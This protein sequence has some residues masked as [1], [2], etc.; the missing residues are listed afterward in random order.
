MVCYPKVQYQYQDQEQ[1]L[2]CALRQRKTAVLNP[3][4]HQLYKHLEIYLSQRFPARLALLEDV[5]SNA[6]MY[7]LNRIDRPDFQ[8]INLH[9]F[10]FGI[11][12]GQLRDQVRKKQYAFPVAPHELPEKAT[13]YAIEE[14]SLDNRMFEAANTALYEWYLQLSSRDQQL[15]EL[16]LKG[17]PQKE[18]AKAFNL[19]YGTVRN[20]SRRLIKKAEYLATL[21]E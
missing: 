9:N 21:T 14:W 7:F 11:V 2:L 20:K 12:L 10:A 4:Y 1:Q 17:Y 8:A 15:L 3:F 16:R 18:I 19:S 13:H 6:F 5:F